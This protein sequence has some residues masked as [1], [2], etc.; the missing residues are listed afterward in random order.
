MRH[1]RACLFA[2]LIACAAATAS[3]ANTQRDRAI[4]LLS[5]ELRNAGYNN[6]SV[7]Q[8]LKDGYVVEARKGDEALV[9]ALDGTTFRVV[10]VQTFAANGA[11]AAGFFGTRATSLSTAGRSALDRY[12]SQLANATAPATQ[13]DVPKLLASAP[14]TAGTAGFSQTGSISATGDVA[15][16][17]RTETLGLLTPHVTET[18]T[19]KGAANTDNHSH[20][21]D[22]SASY[23]RQEVTAVVQ[24]PGGGAFGQQIFSNPEGF[25]NSLSSGSVTLPPV[26]PPIIPPVVLP[27][28]TPTAPAVDRAQV[29]DGVVTA[30]ESTLAQMPANGSP[31]LPANLREQ[32]RTSTL[33]QP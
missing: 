11:A 10:N 2:T 22:H 5:S 17:R 1:A 26:V 29:I 24:I 13:I 3:F 33:P 12:G 15:Q 18:A 23:S 31:T 6:I 20:S 32:L 14:T 19:T 28:I 21:V 30:I 27:V 16:I 4:G 25:R 8:R 9:L 7:T